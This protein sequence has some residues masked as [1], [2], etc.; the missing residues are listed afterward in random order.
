MTKNNT[1]LIG[2]MLIGD[3]LW[4]EGDRIRVRR[5]SRSEYWVYEHDERG[6]S[7]NVRDYRQS[8]REAAN[9]IA[10]IVRSWDRAVVA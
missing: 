4:L 2:G 6:H 1:I 3:T 8:P 5:E 10:V 7:T 9:Y